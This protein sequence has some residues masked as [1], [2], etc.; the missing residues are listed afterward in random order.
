M[1]S[2]IPYNHPSLVLGNIVNPDILAKLRQ[3]GV[4][5]A[6]IDA[7]QD[8]MNAYISMKRSL[9]MTVNELLGMN[10][11]ISALT[12]RVE[13]LDREIA[14]SA[15]DYTG[16]RLSAETELQA[17]KEQISETTVEEVAESPVDFDRTGIRKMPL[18]ADSLQ[19][20]AQYFSYDE[21]EEDNPLGTQASIENYIRESTA[22]LGERTASN[23]SGKAAAQ[24]GL[25]R[26]NHD[27]AGT[28]VI[29]A[30]CTHRQA[31]LLSPFVLDIDKAVSVWN[32]LGTNKNNLIETTDP[33][34]L[35]RAAAQDKDAPGTGMSILSGST[36][37]SSFVGMVH[38]LKQ[39]ATGNSGPSMSAVAAGLQERFKIGS[40]FEESSGG[41]G[42]DPS[43]SSDIKN[44]LSTQRITSHINLIVMGVVPSIRSN[45]VEMGVKTFADVDPAKI[46]A[47]LS[48]ISN[49]TTAAESTVDQAAATAKTGARVISMQGAAIQS[50]M[51]G[52][53]KIDQAG[54]QVM[55][56]NTLMNAFEDYL[57]EVKKGDAGVPIS[58]QVKTVSRSDL[59]RLWLAKYYPDA[60]GN[61]TPTDNPQT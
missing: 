4:I 29:T 51:T 54:N 49:S 5:Q 1:P 43:F 59:I 19:L 37:G 50:V 12:A 46:T 3:I 39:D 22:N 7:A 48:A 35:R 13:E 55:D 18:A 27:L 41:F 26:K 40:W 16:A 33:T 53:G 61:D 52:L 24:I 11:D 45:L 2:S 28:L 14:Q 36:C 20:D 58:F 42:V 56:I 44:L 15:A 31:V 17:L 30:S 21:N 25:Q 60:G 23:I 57:E 10:V 8:K 6:R 47:G 38:V 32:N 9:T 34:G